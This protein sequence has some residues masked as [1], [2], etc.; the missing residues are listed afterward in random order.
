MK[1]QVK[2]LRLIAYIRFIMLTFSDI[3]AEFECFLKHIKE[4]FTHKYSRNLY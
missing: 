4:K 2:Y 1:K 3:F